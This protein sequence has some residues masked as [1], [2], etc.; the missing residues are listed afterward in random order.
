[1]RSTQYPLQLPEDLM[2]EIEATAGDVNLSKADV[3]RQSMKLGLP[4]LREKL[5]THSGRVTNVKALPDAVLSRLYRQRED[6]ADSIR[7]LIAAQPMEA[8]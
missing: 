2:A 6:D 4:Q 3:M 5:S 7:L 8:E 1:M